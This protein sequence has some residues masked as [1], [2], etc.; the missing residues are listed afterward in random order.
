[1]N[2]DNGDQK[3]IDF[4][5]EII[6]HNMSLVNLADT[7]AGML[8]GI[9]GVIIALLFG[10]ATGIVTDITRLLF[11]ITGVS[12]GASSIFTVFAIIPR[13]TRQ[14]DRT[15]MYFMRI[16]ETERSCPSL[17]CHSLTSLFSALQ[18]NP[19]SDLA[20]TLLLNTFARPA[21]NPIACLR[22]SY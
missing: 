11:L 17:S 20:S 9:N 6:D 16:R 1:M 14:H 3:K 12:L 10:G 8:L 22:V 7:K 4:A 5:K 18:G 19:S 13:L 21:I 2:T 15:R